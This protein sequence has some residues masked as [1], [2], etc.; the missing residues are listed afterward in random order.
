MQY[1]LPFWGNSPQSIKIFRIQK[2]I[3]RI[4]MDRTQRDSCRNLFR[5][6]EILPLASQY[7]FSLM[8]FVIRNR[9]EFTDNT[10]IYEIKSRQPKN[11]HQ[12][13]ANLNKYLK[14]IH[15][16]GIKVYNSLP[17]HM[18][19]VSDEP[20]KFDIKL[21]QFLQKNILFIHCRTILIITFLRYKIWT[22]L[23]TRKGK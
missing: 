4:M 8:L 14:G 2:N 15:Y 16:L 17:P 1:G 3:I 7:I 18:K 22:Q 11:L 10:E 20:M 5:A 23:I 12:P 9:K 21:K 19:D 13:L 6:L